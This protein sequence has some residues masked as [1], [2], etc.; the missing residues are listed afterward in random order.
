VL[1]SLSVAYRPMVKAE[2]KMGEEPNIIAIR[3]IC[4]A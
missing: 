2:I 1:S 3:L 4:G